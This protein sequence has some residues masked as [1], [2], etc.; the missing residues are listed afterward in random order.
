[1]WETRTSAENFKAKKLIV[2]LVI[3][4][5]KTIVKVQSLYRLT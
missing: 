2:M 4:Y 1:M 3:N 5:G